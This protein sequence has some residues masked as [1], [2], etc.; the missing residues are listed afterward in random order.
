MRFLITGGAGFLGSALANSL[1]SQGHEVRVVDDLSS[2]DRAALSAE[3]LFTRGDVNNI[4]LLW[5]MLQ[6]VDCVYHL[7]ARVSVAQSILYPRD[8]NAV[9]VGGTVSLMEAMRD[10]GVRRVVLASSGAVYGQQPRH[11]VRESDAPNPD[12]PYS[13]SKLAAEQYVHTIGELWGI[14]TVALRIFNAYGPG[15]G[16]PVSHAPVVPRFLNAILTGGSIVIYG[17]GQQS[18]DFVYSSDVVAA[19]IQAALADQVD[20]Q[21][22]NIGS[23]SETTIAGLIEELEQLT[24]RT[25]DRVINPDQIGGVRR[26]VADISRARKLLGYRPRIPINEGLRLMVAKDPRFHGNRLTATVDD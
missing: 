25:A 14:E 8:Y 23:G 18:R 21:V 26:L 19:L 4:P 9:N 22:I 13:V 20:R 17:D 24:G 6:D 1:A 5:S 12:S 15:Q 11:L 16:L 3:V 2:G 10:A 7:A